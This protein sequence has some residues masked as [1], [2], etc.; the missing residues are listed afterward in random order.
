[1][2]SNIVMALSPRMIQRIVDSTVLIA[3][4]ITNY[5]QK[6]SVRCNIKNTI[7]H[8][9]KDKNIYSYIYIYIDLDLDIYIV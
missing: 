8:R 5:K 3:S 1:M 6:T 2:I 4:S 7:I 9:S